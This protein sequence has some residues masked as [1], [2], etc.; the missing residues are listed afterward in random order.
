MA[1]AAASVLEVMSRQQ[2][3]GSA[4]SGWKDLNTYDLISDYR[5]DYVVYK[6][7]P[8]YSTHATVTSFSFTA[9]IGY[10]GPSEFHNSSHSATIKAYLYASNPV[11][12]G[13]STSPSSPPS[14][15]LD[16]KTVQETIVDFGG[17]NG[18]AIT[19]TFTGL[20]ITAGR[21][22]VWLC[23]TNQAGGYDYAYS[24]YVS[25]TTDGYS[26]PLSISLASGSVTTGNK[27]VVTIVNGSGKTITVEFK[28]NGTRV[29]SG[30]TST[31]QLEVDVTAAWFSAAG[32]TAA[33]SFSVSVTIDLDDTLYESFDV[34]A[35]DDMKPT[36]SN[37][38]LEIV[39]PTGSGAATYYPST[40]IANISKCK[41][42]ASVTLKA[43]ATLP[44]S[45]VKL[46]YTGGA[47][48]TMTYNSS[49]GKY[50][51]TTAALTNTS[52]AFTV[53]ATDSRS[54]SGSQTSSEI[55]VVQYTKPVVNINSS[56]TY[57]CNSS[58]AQE[59]GGAFWRACATATYYSALS[60]N[61]L[62][63]FLVTINTGTTIGLTSGVQSAPQG[64]SLNQTT[65][66]T[67]TFVI[68]DKISEEITKTFILESITRN[69][70]IKRN[71]SGTTAGVGTTPTR[72]A[73]SS[74]ELPLSGDFLMGEIPAQAFHIPYSDIVDGSSF[75][76]DPL[77]VNRTQRK[78]IENA[79][80]F[81]YK[82]ANNSEWNVENLP[83]DY[84]SRSWIGF[85]EVYW[86]NATYQMVSITELIPY[87]GR[88]WTNLCISG[89]WNG[90]RAKQAVTLT[91]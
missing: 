4:W 64:G 17:H 48:V 51:G 5:N 40:Y 73:G 16:V 42:S 57:R 12:G 23:D 55:S 25:A 81:F 3:S 82:T 22:F 49:T 88:V 1:I 26:S 34:V 71:S 43:G 44:S 83:L 46:T 39:Q 61:S 50:E 75:G 37:L 58:G 74:V 15:Y 28:Y 33:D 35:G 30:S 69:V 67:L 53:T 27:Q 21:L 36:V 87:P 65:N 78:S 63:K 38:T 79:S 13:G 41:V 18:T 19:F 24:A 2:S 47:A 6:V 52:T 8:N 10:G 70:V 68:Q 45:G 20:N 84:A 31:G 14:G 60:G 86:M 56:L 90:W 59:S 54:K 62:L 91:T 76:K 80:T 72:A 11:G 66:Y 29:A 89:T 77:N 9:R 32:V 7:E 85:R